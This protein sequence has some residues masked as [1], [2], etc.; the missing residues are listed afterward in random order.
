MMTA[1]GALLGA[2]IAAATPGAGVSRNQLGKG[3]VADP[4]SIQTSAPSDFHIDNVTVAPGGYSG[5]HTHPGTELTIVKS[6][7]LTLFD[8]R[9]PDC[10]PR[11]ISAG[12]GLFIPGGTVHAARNNGDKPVELYV[13]YI[14]PVGEPVRA[15]SD[16]PG[17]CPDS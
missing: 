7:A 16:K 4:I 6:G 9:N 14:V 15:E 10:K 11:T 12:G 5:W 17:N 2:G 1:I 8:T 3:T 13:T